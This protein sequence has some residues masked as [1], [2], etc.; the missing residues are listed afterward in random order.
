MTTPATD[1]VGLRRQIRDP[2]LLIPDAKHVRM[3]DVVVRESSDVVGA[4]ELVLVEH[5]RAVYGTLG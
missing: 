2:V 4:Q 3:L 1:L 5:L